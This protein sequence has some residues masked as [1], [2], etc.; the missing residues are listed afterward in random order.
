MAYL[1]LSE[2]FVTIQNQARLEAIA[3]M[4]EHPVETVILVEITPR[5][6]TPEI[7]PALKD[8]GHRIGQNHQEITQVI[9]SALQILKIVF[10]QKM[11]IMYYPAAKE[12][13]Q[14]AIASH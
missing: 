5:D 9:D 10:V 14:V 8:F 2:Q 11:D 4:S 6:I 3:E 7:Y 1:Q 12:Q 13:M